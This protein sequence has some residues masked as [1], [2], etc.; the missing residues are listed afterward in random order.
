MFCRFEASNLDGR[1][2]DMAS[3]HGALSVEQIQNVM[4]YGAEWYLGVPPGTLIMVR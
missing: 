3:W 4:E 2:D 1:M